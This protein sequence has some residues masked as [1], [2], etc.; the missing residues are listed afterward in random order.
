MHVQLDE[1]GAVV[2]DALIRGDTVREVLDYVQ[3]KSTTLC[4]NSSAATSKPRC[5]KAASAMKNP[6]SLLR[7]YED[8]LNGYTY[9]EQ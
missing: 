7:F 3:F 5:A 9:L 2:I 4:S 6:A 8:G 1:K